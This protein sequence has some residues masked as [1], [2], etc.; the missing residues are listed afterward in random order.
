[1]ESGSPAEQAGLLLG[2]LIVALGDQVVTSVEG[3][4]AALGSDRLGQSI[5][6][7]ILRGGEPR[8]IT[9]TIAERA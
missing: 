3:L 7:K 8:E 4:R 9:A 5:T 6:I 2:D 1:V